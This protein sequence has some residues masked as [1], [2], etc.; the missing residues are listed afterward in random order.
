M[1]SKEM[2]ERLTRVGPG[3]P[4]GAHEVLSPREALPG[5]QKLC[6]RKCT[7][8]CLTNEACE[9]LAADRY[10]CVPDKA[11]LCQACTTDADCPYPADKCVQVAGV[12]VCGRDCSF[13]GKCLA[14]PGTAC[15]R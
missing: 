8:G 12:N 10:A 5:G 2:N 9:P 1:L 15:P 13:D 6:V 7:D 4:L 3:T 14:V 11:A